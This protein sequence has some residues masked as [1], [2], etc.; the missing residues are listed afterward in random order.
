MVLEIEKTY[1]LIG[2]I[3]FMKLYEAKII[4]NLVKTFNLTN[5]LELGFY[6]GV[7]SCYMA[8]TLKEIG[9]GH[10]TTIDLHCAKDQ[11]SPNIEQLLEKCDLREYVTIYY[12]NSYNWRLMKFIQE[13]PD[14]I[15]DFC[16]IDGAHDWYTDALA[17][18]LVD[19]LLK[20]GGWIIFDDINWTFA[21]CNEMKH[22]DY[23]KNMPFEEK[24]IPHIKLI[25]ELLVQRNPNY[26]NFAVFNNGWGIAQKKP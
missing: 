22:F 12:E 11:Y 6:H 24:T 5:L 1:E 7:S 10:L 3:P 18:S 19:K 15:F 25:F 26:C 17:F 8:S 16:F 20:P 9:K 21:E 2:D 14:P 23:V 13:N 4:D